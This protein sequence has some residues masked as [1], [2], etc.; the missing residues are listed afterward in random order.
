MIASPDD[1]TLS[2]QLL[3]PQGMEQLFA[4]RGFAVM[5]IEVDGYWEGVLQDYGVSAPDQLMWL[6]D[7]HGYERHASRLAL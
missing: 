7:R 4:A 1:C 3:A 5:A 6:A 2:L